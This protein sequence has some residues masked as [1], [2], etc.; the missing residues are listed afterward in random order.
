[1]LFTLPLDVPVR[2]GHHHARIVPC[3]IVDTSPLALPGENGTVVW[4]GQVVPCCTTAGIV[5]VDL[6]D[7]RLLFATVAIVQKHG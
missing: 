5:R 3:A 1:M 7:L 2:F 4:R 6:Y